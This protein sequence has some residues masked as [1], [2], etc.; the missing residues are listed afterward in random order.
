MITHNHDNRV[1]RVRRVSNLRGMTL[2]ELLV[3]VSI[4]LLLMTIS[5]PALKPIME[6][7]QTS[8]GADSVS[9]YL[10]S[11]RMRAI[12]TK[13]PCGVL[14]ERL[15]QSPD[16]CLVLR[17]VEVPPY[18]GGSSAN[19]RV[20]VAS[21]GGLID[22]YIPNPAANYNDYNPTDPS[23]FPW[24]TDS[25]EKLYWQKM[26]GQQDAKIQF[27]NQG[28]YYRLYVNS[29]GDYCVD[30]QRYPLVP[31]NDGTNLEFPR[32]T[33]TDESPA[34][35]KIVR[36]AKP[37]LTKPIGLPRGTVVDLNYSGTGKYSIAND[38]VLDDFSQ[39]ADTDVIVMFAPNGEVESINGMAQQGP[40]YFCIGR[41]DR[42][43]P[44]TLLEMDLDDTTPDNNRNYADMTNFWVALNPKS[45]NTSIAPVANPIPAVTGGPGGTPSDSKRLSNSR[46]I[47]KQ[48]QFG[49]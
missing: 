14:F 46:A 35:F 12:S 43:G 31:M 44:D 30:F 27:N 36:G 8:D 29:D 13:R 34:S 20:S 9:L 49:Q 45:G 39:N 42:T 7:K 1:V 10:N 48:Q 18:Y 28:P 37:T 3:V 21:D 2:I 25:S 33:Y 15:E 47:A 6:T 17:Q 38:T 40:V 23:T 5:V 4:I 24:V 22:F 19:V 11:A 26:I 32:V 16:A 41:W